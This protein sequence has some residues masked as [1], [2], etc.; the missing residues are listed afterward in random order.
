MKTN[1]IQRCLFRGALACLTISQC[2]IFQFESPADD[3]KTDERVVDAL[4]VTTQAAKRYEFDVQGASP[5]RLELH[6]ESILRWSNPVAG[7][8]YGNV[9]VWTHQG[10]PQVIGSIYQWYSPWTHGSHEFHS[11]AVDPLR[12]RRSNK[13][14]WST[15]ES[16]VDWQPV[17]EAPEG[18]A[19]ASLRLRQARAISRGFQIEKTDRENV[20]RQLRLLAQPIYRYG[21]PE[22]DVVDGM[23]FVFVQGTDPEVFLMLEARKDGE[24]LQ[25]YFALS[26][27]NSVQFVANY[28]GHEVW[29]A[30]I[31]P[32]S[33]VKDFRHSPYV[34]FGRFE[35]ESESR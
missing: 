26:R 15:E 25:W 31:L 24:K 19:N 16:G 29:R 14:V 5:H 33:A 6:P 21:A 28:Q 30:E 35:R 9:F 17:P 7:E 27:M 20:S 23:L 22:S 2:L 3:N 13:L 32:W 12:G 18:A 4:K 8:I 10:R 34:S 11:L 1:Q